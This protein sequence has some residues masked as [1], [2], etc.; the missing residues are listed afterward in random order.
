M[1]RH[2]LGLPGRDQLKQHTEI[3]LSSRHRCSTRT[4]RSFYA[5][6]GSG[7][8]NPCTQANSVPVDI[9]AVR[10]A[11]LPFVVPSEGQSKPGIRVLCADDHSIVRDGIAFAIQAVPDMELVGE[12]V[13]GEGAIREFRRL[14]PDIALVDLHMPVLDGFLAMARIREEFPKA[15]LIA[16]TE[17]KG[18]VLAS[19]AFRAGAS[20]I[21][22]KDTSRSEMLNTIRAV[23]LGKKH[24]PVAIASCLADHLGADD[25]T[26]REL[27][28]LQA[29]ARGRS[30]K[31]IA[32]DLAISED[33]VKGH[34]KN[35]MVKLC[36]NDRTH[37]VCI[38]LRRGFMQDCP[39]ATAT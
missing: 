33:T 1:G 8:R 36:A 31:I 34:L 32:A 15:R 37:A 14:R 11:G 2:G 35:I 25:L 5:T 24:V 29:V 20:G 12:T 21:L 6:D 16:L 28:V 3:R 27:E 13:N 7:E 19:R 22:L 30:N 26:P 38:A 10:A 18:D 23:S 9:V 4:V 39:Q 17:S